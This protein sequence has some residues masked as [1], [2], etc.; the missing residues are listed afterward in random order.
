MTETAVR[1]QAGRTRDVPMPRVNLLPPEVG[2]AQRVRRARAALAAVVAAAVAAVALAWLA[3]SS[4]TDQ[5][6]R[7]LA[8][9]TAEN[10][11]L[12]AEAAPLAGVPAVYARADAARAQ[13]ARAMGSEVRY[14]RYLND[15]AVAVPD[16]VWLTN[17]SVTQGGDTAQAPGAAPS[18]ASLGTVGF[19]GKAL[20][21]DDVAAFVVALRRM[22]ANASPSFSDSQ[23]ER[24]GDRDVVS[25]VASARLAPA[26]LSNRYPA[27]GP[28]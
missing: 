25:Y 24:L 18:A 23:T 1:E 2:H 27:A 6:G 10:G 16:G 12:S 28:R 8:A 13:L 9:A 17:L 3:A 4:A 22:P 5:A 14:S 20:A 7:E 26:A 15:L 21:H 19:T 11:R